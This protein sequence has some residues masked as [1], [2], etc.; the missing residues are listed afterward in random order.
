MTSRNTQP[1]RSQTAEEHG[2]DDPVEN[3]DIPLPTEGSVTMTEISIDTLPPSP[4]DR[5]TNVPISILQSPTRTV[6]SV[7]TRRRRG[8]GSSNTIRFHSTSNDT[9]R[10]EFTTTSSFAL[11]NLFSMMDSLLDEEIM[12][13][14]LHHSLDTYHEHLFQKIDDDSTISVQ[15]PSRLIQDETVL[16]DMEDRK[17]RIC[18]EDFAVHDEVTDL[19]CHHIFHSEC[20]R[21]AVI[22]QHSQCP[23]CRAT[24]PVNHMNRTTP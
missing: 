17:C 4:F 2:E 22:R 24:I 20:I 6:A 14:T 11:S 18:L 10:N 3:P 15:C 1:R 7:M 23:L 16:H 12:Q 19:T 21:N 8:G 13:R 5:T 9:D